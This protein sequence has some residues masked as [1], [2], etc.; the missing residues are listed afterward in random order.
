MHDVCKHTEYLTHLTNILDAF[1]IMRATP[2]I[3]VVI[4]TRDPLERFMSGL[5]MVDTV[6][7]VQK[8]HQADYYGYFAYYASG[9]RANFSNPNVLNLLC[10]Y[11]LGN[12]H[13]AHHL[14]RPLMLIAAG[15]NVQI[16]HLS[17]YTEHLIKHYPHCGQ[18]ITERITGDHQCEH[19]ERLFASYQSV[20]GDSFQCRYSWSQWIAEEIKI[21]QLLEDYRAGRATA[22]DAI[23]LF[24]QLIADDIYFSSVLSPNFCIACQLS[25]FLAS[26]HPVFHQFNEY[27]LNKTQD[28][29]EQIKN[30]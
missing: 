15:Y 12:S 16:I 11:D 8:R 25:D 1:D 17:E 10:P 13:T 2:E 23:C 27:R 22:Q 21:Y 20:F 26:R 19:R 24:K 28:I 4:S 9:Q 7:G 5:T 6:A 3:P 18:V 30:Y 14:F 29:V